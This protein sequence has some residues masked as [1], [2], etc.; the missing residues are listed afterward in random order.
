M[1]GPHTLQEV[2]PFLS[3][4]FGDGDLIPLPLQAQLAPWI[5]RRRTPKIQD[6]Y[7]QIGGG[8]PIRMWT[9]RQGQLIESLLDKLS[10]ETGNSQIDVF[11]DL[12]LTAEELAWIQA[13]S[14][15]LP[16]T[17]PLTEPRSDFS[18]SDLR[19]SATR[20]IKPD[21]GRMVASFSH[22]HILDDDIYNDNPLVPLM[23][24]RPQEDVRLNGLLLTKN[25]RLFEFTVAKLLLSTEFAQFISV[26]L[27]QKLCTFKG[28]VVY[29]NTHLKVMDEIIISLTASFT[30]TAFPDIAAP[31]SLTLR[32][33]SPEASAHIASRKLALEMLLSRTGL[34]ESTTSSSTSRN[35]NSLG[36]GI[37]NDHPT[38]RDSTL[39]MQRVDHENVV[40]TARDLD[41][42]YRRANQLG[43]AIGTMPP[44]PGMTLELRAYQAVALA[45]MYQKE[46]QDNMASTGISPLFKERKAGTG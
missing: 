29:A 3:R 8:S 31:W 32:D 13:D 33:D 7:A 11:G 46:N 20:H 45:F 22:S 5:A 36:N 28:T 38:N 17:E 14:M 9:E 30:A 19:S 35:Q 6:Q 24:Q 43:K 12:Q 15:S 2:G 40:P 21:P 1:G 37:D 27:D 4:L 39:Q 44:S 10:P 42:V 34:M 25:T 26:L 41:I 23:H 18:M 16:L